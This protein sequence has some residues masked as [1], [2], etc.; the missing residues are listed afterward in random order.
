MPCILEQEEAADSVGMGKKAS[1]FISIQH[2]FTCS[3]V[4]TLPTHLQEKGLALSG[5][6]P[7]V[8]TLLFQLDLVLIS[9]F[10]AENLGHLTWEAV[11]PPS[12]GH[13]QPRSDP[14]CLDNL[15]GQG[16]NLPISLVPCTEWPF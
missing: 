5:K 15:E 11:A 16:L 6:I 8:I 7:G 14:C 12:L 2:P 4:Q 1:S 9:N 10:W 13:F 3:G